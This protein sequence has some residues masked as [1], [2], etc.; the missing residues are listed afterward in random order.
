MIRMSMCHCKKIP[1]PD[2]RKMCF[3]ETYVLKISWRHMPSDLC[4]GLGFWLF[5][6]YPPIDKAV[7]GCLNLI[8]AKL[9]L[10]FN[11]DFFFPL[12]ESLFQII[13]SVPFRT[14]NHQTVAK[15]KGIECSF[16]ASKSK[17]RFHTN[18]RLS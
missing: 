13:S 5:T 17:I 14:S 4:R 7:P 3:W 11:L 8:S 18:P 12:F 9:V 6:G 15:R 16:K 1:F 10:Y 2:C